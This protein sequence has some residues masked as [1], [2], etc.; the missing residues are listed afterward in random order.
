MTERALT[1]LGW[2]DFRAAAWWLGL[3]Y[4]RP[5]HFR[6]ALEALPKMRMLRAGVILMTHALIYAIFIA[7]AGRLLLFGG[8]GLSLQE[9]ASN[10]S[11]LFLAH[12]M[13]LASGSPWDRWGRRIAGTTAQIVG[14]AVR[15]RLDGLGIALGSKESSQGSPQDRL[16]NRL[17]DCLWIGLGIFGGIARGIV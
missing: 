12:A 8:F 4:R 14:I 13:V 2:F 1:D 17:R 9:S 16:R 3:L 11:P 6:E 5:K 10:G 7:A 15:D